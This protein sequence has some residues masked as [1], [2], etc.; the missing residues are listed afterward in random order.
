MNGKCCSLR[1]AELQR[2][3]LQPVKQKQKGHSAAAWCESKNSVISGIAASTFRGIFPAGH[4]RE[5][6]VL[7]SE[8]ADPLF[9][10]KEIFRE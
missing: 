10:A 8:S 2:M 5:A 7:Y 4:T 3:Q 1:V 9:K 6:E